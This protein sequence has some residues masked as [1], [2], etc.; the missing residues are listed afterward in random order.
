MLTRCILV[1][2]RFS[3]GDSTFVAYNVSG[4]MTLMEN[5]YYKGFRIEPLPLLRTSDHRW[6]LDVFIDNPIGATQYS[7][8]STYASRE[9][10]VEAGLT[11]GRD[12][13]DG[14]VVACA[15]PVKA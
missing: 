11:L 7:A 5:N 12:I 14:R 3:V 2:R 8:G 1:T 4:V 6:I 15:P 13:I 10:A 9:V